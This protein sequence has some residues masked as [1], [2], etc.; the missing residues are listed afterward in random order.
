[1]IS[2]SIRRSA[3]SKIID[4]R[5]MTS[6]ASHAL[7]DRISQVSVR[8]VIL[9]LDHVPFGGTTNFVAASAGRAW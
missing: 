9:G 2:M 6:D 7:L 1:M 4:C 5:K 3:P 8:T